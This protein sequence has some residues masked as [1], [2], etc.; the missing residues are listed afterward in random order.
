MSTHPRDLEEFFH[1]R[2][3]AIELIDRRRHGRDVTYEGDGDLFTQ[4]WFP[5]CR[6][7]EV[8]PGA[9]LGRNFLDGRVAVYRTEDGTANVVSAYCPHNGADLSIGK[10]A[11]DRLVCAFHHWEFDRSGRCS[12]T[13]TGDRI[14]EGMKVF[15]YPVQERFGL[16]WAFNGTEPLFDLP[17][18]GF[19]DEDL[20]FHADIPSLDLLADPWV[21]MCNTSDF[22]H[23]EVVH[24]IDIQGDATSDINWHEFGYD[25]DLKGRFRETGAAIEYKVGIRGSNIFYQMGSVNGRWFAFL[26]PCGIHRPGTLRSYFVIATRKSDGTPEDDARVAETLD[27]AQKLE[28][29]VV[30]QDVE[31]LNSIRFTRGMFTRSDKAL[32]RFV[33]YLKSYPRAHPGADFIR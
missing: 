26:Y 22:N 33:D 18:L 32:G 17:E 28:I 1:G 24:G 10:V 12:A 13:P 31:I 30:D 11:G 9:V 27:F 15:R 7:S 16:I 29:A 25:Y 2:T 20:A 8:A 14:V 19:P 4:S 5:L 6:S 3:A 21:F 23:I